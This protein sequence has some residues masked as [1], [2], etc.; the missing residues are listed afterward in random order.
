MKV[1]PPRRE[2]C[3]FSN[4]A[5]AAGAA[6]HF[7]LFKGYANAHRKF[8]LMILLRFRP[9]ADGLRSMPRGRRARLDIMLP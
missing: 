2:K 3:G 9:P 1:P 6:L 5:A 8:K 7:Q 4:A